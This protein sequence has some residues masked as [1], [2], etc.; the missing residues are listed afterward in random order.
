MEHGGDCLTLPTTKTFF[1]Y[2]IHIDKPVCHEVSE[3]LAAPSALS[4]A[5]SGCDRRKSKAES[6]AIDHQRSCANVIIDGC[7]EM[8]VELGIGHF[9]QCAMHVSLDS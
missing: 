7:E 1:L 6:R 9:H 4:Q 2:H 8:A 3:A 5:I